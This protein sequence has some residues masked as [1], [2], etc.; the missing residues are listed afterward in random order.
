MSAEPGRKKAYSSDIRWR[1]IYQRVGMGLTFTEIAKNLNIALST[2]HRTFSTF[3]RNGTVEPASRNSS[4]IEMRI[5]DQ[6]G[7]LYVIGLVLNSPTLYL[8]EIVQL[9]KN[10]LGVDL[11]AAT[12]CR[13]LKR[14]GHTRKKVRQVAQQR[15][16]A[17][18]GHF[19]AHIYL[20]TSESFV[21]IDETGSNKKDHIRK[22][23]YALKGV[24]PVYHRLLCRGERYNAIAAISCTEV[25]AVEVRKGS[26]NGTLFYN[27]LR[28]ELFP[29]MHSFPGP[30][31]VAIMD[32]C[33]I[34]HVQEVQDLA[35][36]LGIILLYLPPYS[37]DYNPIEESFSYVKTY[38]WKHDE[39]LQSIPDPTCIIKAAFNSITS[40]H[41]MSWA[42]H[43]GYNVAK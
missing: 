39:L 43:A 38:L 34:H 33:S 17:L 36:Q 29:R 2:A 6:Q 25:L 40:D 18:R 24:T 41:L 21:W 28:G 13:L 16:A 35:K 4:R 7:E 15:C 20:Y 22:Y 30:N 11:S 8:G 5:L 9:V 12:I 1:I 23:G 19:M 32:N 37:P 14:Y 10:D 3:E 27:F 26:V 42:S 31:S